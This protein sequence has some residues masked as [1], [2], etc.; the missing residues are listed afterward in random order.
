MKLLWVS[1]KLPLSKFIM[2]G[3]S[4]PVSHFA[5][6]FD[7]KIV[8]HSDLTGVHIAWLDTFLKTHTVVYE[9]TLKMT[10][11][12]EEAVYQ[13]IISKYDGKGYDY[14]GFL[15]FC[16]RGFLKKFFKKAMPEKNIWGS[17]RGFLCTEMVSVLPDTIVPKEIKEMDLAMVSPYV[18]WKLF[19][20]K[21]SI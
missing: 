13:N 8:F 11:K 6:V 9:K 12:Q 20:N 16:Y 21:D 5:M 4:E 10:L 17:K 2:W 1:G 3:L 15:Y 19:V 18:L 7:N 14:G